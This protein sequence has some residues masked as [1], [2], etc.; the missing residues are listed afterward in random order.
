MS[1]SGVELK[2]LNSMSL[3]TD[4]FLL[5]RKIRIHQHKNVYEVRT[6][7]LNL[8]I[9]PIANWTDYD[10]NTTSTNVKIHDGSVYILLF[11]QYEP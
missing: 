7:S 2:Q 4:V 11:L 10:T 3:N 8:Y 1:K 6:V 9:K 5:R